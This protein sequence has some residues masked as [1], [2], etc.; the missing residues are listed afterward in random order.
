MIEQLNEASERLERLR[1]DLERYERDGE[2]SEAGR[3]KYGEIPELEKQLASLRSDLEAIPA[4]ER[5]LRDQVSADDIASVVARWTGVPVDRLLES[6]TQ[7]LAHLEER[8]GKRVIN[9][10][11]AVEAVSDAIRRSR[12]GIGD[13][14]RP[15]GSFLFLGPTG[16]GKTELAR[17]L[18]ETLFNDE[19]AITRID[20]GEYME[21]HAVARLIGSPPGYVGYEQGG[22]L[23]EAV[24]RRP[25]SIVLF[26]E[27][28]KAH[29]DIFNTL[30]QVL[31]DGR[32]TDGQGRTVNF[33]NTIIIMTS[34]VAQEIDPNDES[35]LHD[36]LRKFF[37]PEF[38]NR[39]DDIVVFK[40]IDRSAMRQIV[41]AQLK[42]V[43]DDILASK[44]IKLEFSD[45]AKDWLADRGFDENYGARPLKRLI[46]TALLN[47]LAKDII[48]GSVVGNTTVRVEA[49]GDKLSLRSD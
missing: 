31:D 44:D 12:A 27:I 24:R 38:I 32:L 2:L 33:K 48:N 47:P 49:D 22:Q 39:I 45:S 17:S 28:E 40:P 3:I 13:Q 4:G 25:Y 46:Q 43:A 29:P 5:M 11:R 15:I 35:A 34:N 19:H 41:D 36:E 9:Q 8:I 23:T 18:A 21:Q 26:D 10:S 16:V 42:R 7:K 6:E 30:L 37:K 1:S 14:N 20:M